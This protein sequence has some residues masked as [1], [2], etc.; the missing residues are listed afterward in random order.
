MLLHT[1]SVERRRHAEAGRADLR[2]RPAAQSPG[3]DRR[4]RRAARRPA[5]RKDSGDPA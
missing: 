2:E 5:A 4:N 1:A 3:R